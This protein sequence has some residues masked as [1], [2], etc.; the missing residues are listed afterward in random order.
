MS[1]ELLSGVLKDAEVSSPGA[2][3]DAS[4]AWDDV[5]RVIG[6]PFEPN[7]CIVGQNRDVMGLHLYGNFTLSPLLLPASRYPCLL[8]AVNN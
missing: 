4:D 7:R 2:A 8:Y 6:A 3:W 5:K 1:T